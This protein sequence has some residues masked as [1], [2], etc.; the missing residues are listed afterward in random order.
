MPAELRGRAV[1]EA[2]GTLPPASDSTAVV[3]SVW[4][5]WRT[6][7][8]TPPPVLQPRQFQACFLTLIE[9]LS[10]PP[11]R[12][13]G[14]QRSIRPRRLMWRRSSSRSI[15]TMRARSIKSSKLIA[16]FM[17]GYRSRPHRDLTVVMRRNPAKYGHGASPSAVRARHRDPAA[18]QKACSNFSVWAIATNRYQL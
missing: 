5:M 15:G 11:H 9:N 4:S 7:E 2:N 1:A 3:K 6:S 8:I 13:H 17:R 10:R 16:L 18:R 14:P 12:G